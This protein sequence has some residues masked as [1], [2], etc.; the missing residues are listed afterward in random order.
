MC[1]PSENV[2]KSDWI[3]KGFF[4]QVLESIICSL[5]LHNNFYSADNQSKM[6]HLCFHFPHPEGPPDARSQSKTLMVWLQNYMQYISEHSSFYF[7][8]CV[9]LTAFLSIISLPINSLR[10]NR[11]ANIQI[12]EVLILRWSM[13]NSGPV[14]SLFKLLFQFLLE[15]SW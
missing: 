7:R 11:K 5:C 6:L 4:L 2:T 14:W 1:K 15:D 12:S 13:R 10:S 3:I 8:P 9:H